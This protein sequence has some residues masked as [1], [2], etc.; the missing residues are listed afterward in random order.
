[1]EH[2]IDAPAEHQTRPDKEA[3]NQKKTGPRTGSGVG[4]VDSCGSGA[5]C[6]VGDLCMW[7]V[8]KERRKDTV[9]EA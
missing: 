5:F 9:N 4:P 7:F 2:P 1:M 6:A 3:G 8:R